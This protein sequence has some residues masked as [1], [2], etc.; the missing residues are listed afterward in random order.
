MPL[1]LHKPLGGSASFPPL[2]GVG[3][4]E[5]EG[6]CPAPQP[7]GPRGEQRQEGGGAG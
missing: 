2:C 4:G 5:R 3:G 7:W 6:S 1:A